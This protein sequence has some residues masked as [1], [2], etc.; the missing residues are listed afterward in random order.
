[1]KK[2]LISILLLSL[3][4]GI[5]SCDYITH[6]I[7][8]TPVNNGAA[9][10]DI[11]FPTNP[12]PVRKMLLEDYTGHTCGNC[13]GAA[14]VITDSIVPAFGDKVIPVGVHAGD[15]ALVGP[16]PFQDDFRTDAGT[17]FDSFFELSTQ[18]GNPVGM[19]N[20]RDYNNTTYAHG[21]L[22]SKWKSYIDTAIT[23]ALDADIQLVNEYDSLTKKVCIHI[24]TNFLNNLSGNYKLI[25]WMIQDSI[26]KAQ[27]DYSLN[28]NPIV[29]NY[30]HRHVLRAAI[31]G[32]WGE[33]VI[34]SNQAAAGQKIYKKYQYSFPATIGTLAVEVKHCYIVAFVYNAATYEVIQA[35]EKKVY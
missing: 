5:Q 26:I 31:N 24:E 32:T 8:G 3:F 23:K 12:S 21:K 15:F 29:L 18:C 10:P 22:P 19:I 7:E 25:V 30:I 16:S 1:M 17:T 4:I 14:R 6:P 28:P 20:R 9:C 27:E 2:F 35:E 13:P 11:T 34:S 33:D